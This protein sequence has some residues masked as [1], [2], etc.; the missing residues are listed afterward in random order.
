MKDS[1]EKFLMGTFNF[2]TR[3]LAVVALYW[4]FISDV[5]PIDKDDAVEAVKELSAE[6][7]QKALRE[8]KR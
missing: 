1:I 5:S 6:Q 4:L 7:L 8:V 2:I 3:V